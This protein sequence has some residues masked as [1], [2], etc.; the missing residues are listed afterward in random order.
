MN[1][2]TSSAN[3]NYEIQS[4]PNLVPAY[5]VTVMALFA[6]LLIYFLIKKSKSTETTS[7]PQNT[8]HATQSDPTTRR[9]SPTNQEVQLSRLPTLPNYR[10]LSPPYKEMETVYVTSQ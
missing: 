3:P 5:A 1:N 6:L 8:A 10:D 9:Q 4:F 7:I 2:T